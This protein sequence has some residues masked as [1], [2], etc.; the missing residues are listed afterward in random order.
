M[1]R[2]GIRVG[3]G[4]REEG[5]EELDRGGGIVRMGQELGRHRMWQLGGGFSLCASKA[6]RE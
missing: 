3:V 6:E 2:G 5:D 4:V 1:V